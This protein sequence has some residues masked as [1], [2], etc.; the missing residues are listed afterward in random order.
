MYFAPIFPHELILPTHKASKLALNGKYVAS[1]AT[2]DSLV[3][4]NGKTSR[5][6]HWSANGAPVCVGS[7]EGFTS[8]LGAVEHGAKLVPSGL[9]EENAG[10]KLVSHGFEGKLVNEK[11]ISWF[12]T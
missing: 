3:A 11:K 6:K 8:G 1:V 9:V 5:I 10:G 12:W 7:G 2:S 4:R